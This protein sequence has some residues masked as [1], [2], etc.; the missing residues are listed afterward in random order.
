VLTKHHS[1]LWLG[2]GRVSH[3]LAT[4]KL[5]AGVGVCGN[6]VADVNALFVF[7]MPWKLA[8]IHRLSHH[9]RPSISSN[10]IPLLYLNPYLLLANHPRVSWQKPLPGDRPIGN[11]E[12]CKP[13]GGSTRL[14]AVPRFEW[15]TRLRICIACRQGTTRRRSPKT[16]R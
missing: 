16:Q 11:M 10:I 1:V 8:L 14:P 3:L 13:S 2:R 4:R 5:V 7:A 9:C 12:K 6:A 15:T